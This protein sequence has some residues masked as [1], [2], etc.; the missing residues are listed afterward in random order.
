MDSFG[1]SF[2]PSD[3]DSEER[4]IKEENTMKILDYDDDSVDV[5]MLLVCKITLVKRTAKR[6]WRR[7]GK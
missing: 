3:A 5:V 7:A 4:A 1:A 6:E 2:S